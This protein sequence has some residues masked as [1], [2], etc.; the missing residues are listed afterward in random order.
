MTSKTLWS[1]LLSAP[2][3]T[4]FQTQWLFSL[5][6][7]VM[8]VQTLPLWFVSSE[9]HRSSPCLWQ[10]PDQRVEALRYSILLGL[11]LQEAKETCQY[12]TVSC[13]GLKM[14]SLPPNSILQFATVTALRLL[15]LY[16][17]PHPWPFCCSNTVLQ[18]KTISSRNHLSWVCKFQNWMLKELFHNL[19]HLRCS[20][21]AM[22]NRRRYS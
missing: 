10:C 21:T 18:H 5:P 13:C 4:S 15:E 22:G 9:K 19:P 17:S 20:V 16:R 8:F 14:A 7:F 1:L 12:Y 6:C 2:I 11:P 3:R